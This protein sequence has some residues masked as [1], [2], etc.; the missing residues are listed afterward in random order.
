M[1]THS[2][3]YRQ[4]PPIADLYK[5]F[6]DGFSDYIVQFDMDEATFESVFLVRD[7]NQP[8]RSIVAYVDNRPVGLMLSGIARLETGWVT[9]CGGLAIAPGYRRLGLAQEF[10][11]RFDMQAEGTRLLEVIQGNDRAL[12][13][14]YQLGYE[15]V[16]EIFYYQSVQ[17]DTTATV[18]PVPIQ[19]LFEKVYPSANHHPIW[20]RDLRT[21]QQQATLLRVTEAGRSG[22]LLLRDHVLLDVFGRDEDAVWLL[23]AA[24]SSH[25]LHMTLTSDRPAFIQAAETLGFVKGEIM[26]YEMVKREEGIT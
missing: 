9:R 10:M 13:L 5:A 4:N 11:R 8:S 16:R 7:Q 21:T 26:Q 15:V 17:R 20:Q 1:T 25:P 24:A 6:T 19:T 2:I 18:E 12:R 22:F 3:T 23:E 14:Y